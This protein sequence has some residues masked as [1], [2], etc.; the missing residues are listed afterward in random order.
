M[1]IAEYMEMSAIDI[2]QAVRARRISPV[3][4]TEAALRR[5]DETEPVINAFATRTAE[6]ALDQACRAEAAVM[7]GDALGRMHGVPIS[8]KDLI[9]VAGVRQSFGSRTR[10]GNIASVDA[11]SVERLRRSGACLV[12]KTTTTEFGVKAAGDS[13]LTGLTRNPWHLERTTGGSSCGA[14]ASVA[15]GVTPVGIGTDGGGSIRIPSAFCGLFGTK[16]QFG[17]VPVYPT[18]ATPTLGHVGPLARSVRDAALTLGVLAGYDARDPASVTEPVPD[19]LAACDAGIK[20]LRV[21][22]SPTLGYARPTSE[23]RETC[24]AAVRLFEEMGCEVE[25]VDRVFDDDPFDIFLADFYAGVGVQLREPLRS[26]RELL[27]QTVLGVLDGALGQSLDDYMRA[28]FKRYAL[29]ERMREFFARFDLLLTPTVPV[30]AFDVALEKPAEL[31]ERSIV[32]WVFYT[33]PFNLTGQPAA[34]IPC[35]F[36]ADGLPLG[37]QLVARAYREVDLF[38]AAAAYEAMRP[39]PNDRP[40]QALAGGG[41]ASGGSARV[42][43]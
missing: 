3:E 9:A 33:Y 32:N 22:W 10:A 1:N 21:A 13:P 35:G 30:P 6:L 37:L 2:G 28:L 24:S 19:F 12:G 25:E 15:A 17:R 38:R 43:T 20:G 34:S 42:K 18:S 31:Q 14:A 11:P 29:R 5:I 4:V 39:W 26:S 7:R 8:V 36:S 27:D 41:S 40:M 16:A 23:V